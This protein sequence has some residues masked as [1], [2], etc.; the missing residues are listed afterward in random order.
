MWSEEHT[1]FDSSFDALEA[2]RADGV[3]SWPFDEFEITEGSKVQTEVLECISSLV[4]Q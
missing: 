4:D 3:H 1:D 2:M